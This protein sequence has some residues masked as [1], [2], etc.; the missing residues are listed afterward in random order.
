MRAFT[1]IEEFHF[2]TAEEFLGAPLV[3]DFLLKDWLEPLAD[4]GS[5]GRVL[6]SVSELIDDE[7]H[8]SEFSLSIKATLVVGQKTR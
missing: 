5:H 1:S 6:A 3:R 2:A 7:R 8:E 4:T